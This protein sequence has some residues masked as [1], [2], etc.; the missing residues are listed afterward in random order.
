MAETVVSRVPEVMDLELYAGDG[1]TFRFSVTDANGEPFPLD[2]VATSQI[3]AKRK[4]PDPLLEWTVDESE[5]ESGVFILSLSG[6][7]TASLIKD[8]RTFNGV[9]DLQYTATDAEPKTF[10][11]GKV[12]CYA[13]VTR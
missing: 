2:G 7:Q 11:Q 1:S 10:I 12:T 3:R 4:D 6:T 8:G 13:D 9:W 5:M